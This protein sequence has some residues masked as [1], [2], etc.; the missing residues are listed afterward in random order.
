[1]K[2]IAYLISVSF[3][4][5]FSAPAYECHAAAPS[6]SQDVPLPPILNKPVEFWGMTWGDSPDKLGEDKV[7]VGRTDV[8]SFEGYD[9][10]RKGMSFEEFPVSKVCF[11]FSREKK[12]IAVAVYFKETV[13]AKTLLRHLI[14]KYGK[15][16]VIKEEETKGSFWWRDDDFM[17]D[18]EIRPK[19]PPILCFF[20]G[21]LVNE[22]YP[23]PFNEE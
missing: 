15:L 16:A 13:E 7:F 1:M 22:Q 14:K 5:C 18:L 17:I 12:L 8:S 6:A 23:E 9:L 2:K 20:N 11:G 19:S 10:Q 21:K 4:L 3:V